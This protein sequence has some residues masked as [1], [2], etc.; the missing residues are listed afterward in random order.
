M[1]K[2]IYKAESVNE[3]IKN[4][5]DDLNID[6]S[7]AE[8]NIIEQGNKGFLG[9]I[10]KKQAQIEIIIE[11]DPIE[12]GKE[13]LKDIFKNTN[14]DVDINVIQ[15]KTNQE[16]VVYDVHS[17]D[18]GI[19]IGRRG[20]TLDALQYLTSLVVN[21]D[22]EDYLRIIID[23]EGYRER[24]EKTLER[25][26]KKLAQKAVSK[27]RKVVLEPMPP[28]ERRI[29]HI[30]LKE[31]SRVKSYSEGEEPFRKVMIETVD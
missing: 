10:G 8:I 20:E 25:L 30:T 1:E 26:A 5:L 13:F 11:E 22:T 31:D 18:L 4:G 28:H 9:L 16:Q 24:R 21:R 2:K 6:R 12:K 27:G 14:L 19:V 29:I 17:P 7:K 23:A 3:A 15:S